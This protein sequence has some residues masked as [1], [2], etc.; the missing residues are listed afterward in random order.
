MPT[1]ALSPRRPALRHNAIDRRTASPS[2]ALTWIGR[3]AVMLSALCMA[4]I[5]AASL[6]AM[7]QD[8]AAQSHTNEDEAAGLPRRL[9]LRFV[10][11][12]DFPP[13]NFYDEEGQ[14]TGFNVDLARSICL[15]ARATC[16]VQVKPWDELLLALRRGE[17][18]AAIAGHRITA[19]SVQQVDFSMPYLFTPGR[20]AVRRAAEK[21]EITPEGL[22]GQRI[23]VIR[24]SAHEAFLKTFFRDSRIEIYPSSDSAREALAEG[25]IDY[26]FDDG[27]SLSFWL[28]GTL[29]NQCCE[30]RGGPFLE[31]KYFGDGIAVAIKKND[32]QMKEL[33]NRSI[34][35]LRDSG[36]FEELVGRYFPY[37]IY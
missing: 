33:I 30:F 32:R 6:P 4:L 27:I 10:T 18:D 36:R 14:L 28:N 21:R 1:E 17:A 23:A 2:D 22:E 12:A 25:K 7:A 31:A 20:F 8:G 13:F 15:E 29:S 35:D 34:A 3:H 11:E 37:R 26:L 16:D 5:F 19:K 24:G 9:V